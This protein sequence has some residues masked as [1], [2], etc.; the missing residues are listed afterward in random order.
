MARS[1][2]KSRSHHDVAHLHPQPLS[3]PSIKILHLTVSEKQP[4]QALSLW[5]K[6]CNYT[7]LSSFYD[8]R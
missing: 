6:Q 8:Y 5:G 2:V 4:E 3:L 7:S 1:K